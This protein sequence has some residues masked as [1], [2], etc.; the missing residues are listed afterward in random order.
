MS[1]EVCSLQNIFAPLLQ[2]DAHRSSCTCQLPSRQSKVVQNIH[3]EHDCLLQ[4]LVELRIISFRPRVERCQSEAS[5]QRCNH[6][7]S[8]AHAP[9]KRNMNHGPDSCPAWACVSLLLAQYGRPTYELPS[10]SRGNSS[11]MRDPCRG[12]MPLT[13]T[14]KLCENKLHV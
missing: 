10:S 5:L 7:P 4:D 8:F 9:Q 11:Y 3:F 12:D 6:P 14:H 13:H 1:R 2:G